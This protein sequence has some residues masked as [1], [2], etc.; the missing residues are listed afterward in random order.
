MRFIDFIW[1]HLHIWGPTVC[2]LTYTGSPGACVPGA[3][4]SLLQEAGLAMCSW[5]WQRSKRENKPF[6]SPGCITLVTIPLAKASWHIWAKSHLGGHYNIT[7]LSGVQRGEDPLIPHNHSVVA[8]I[9]L[10]L[11]R[12]YH[13]LYCGASDNICRILSSFIILWWLSWHNI[14]SVISSYWRWNS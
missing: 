12:R 13:F 5:W 1:T 6:P 9:I 11:C 2:W 7:P 3:H 4:V 14:L 10:L 8:Q